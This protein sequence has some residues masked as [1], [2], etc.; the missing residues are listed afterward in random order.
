V[1]HVTGGFA[2]VRELGFVTAG[3]DYGS[4][5]NIQATGTNATITG[6][7]FYDTEV[8]VFFSSAGD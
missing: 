8:I 7:V 4:I 3:S 5:T 2:M 6:A 1:K